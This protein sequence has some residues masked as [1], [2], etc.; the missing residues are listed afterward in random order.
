MAPLEPN[1]GIVDHGRASTRRTGDPP[2]GA[3]RGS[4]AT[5]DPRRARQLTSQAKRA[6]SR[7]V[8]HRPSISPIRVERELGRNLAL[9]MLAAVGVGISLAL[10]TTL[11]PT[12]ARRG[13]LEPLGLAALAAAPFIANLLGV[14]AGRF[15]PRSPRQLALIRVAGSASLS[16]CSSCRRRPIMVVVS[17][18]FWLSLSFGGPFHLRLWGA[19]YPARLRGRVV[20]LLGMGRA[21]AGAL[22]AFGGGLLADHVGGPPAV[23]L[24]GLIG[25][26]VRD[27]LRRPAGPGGRRPAPVLGARLHPR[28]SRASRPRA[29]G[30][31]PGLLRRRPHR[32]GARCT[33]SSM[34]TG[35]TCRSSDV[36]IIG[37]LTAARDDRLVPGLGRR[38]R[39]VRRDGRDADRQRD[40][41]GRLASPTPWHRTSRCC[42]SRPWPP[43]RGVPRSTSASPRSSA[44]TPRMS[45]RAPAMAGWNAITGARGIVAAFLMSALLQAGGRRRDDRT[46]AVCRVVGG[47]GRALHAD[48]RRRAGRDGHDHAGPGRPGGHGPAS[49]CPPL[50]LGLPED[51]GSAGAGRLVITPSARLRW[52]PC[53]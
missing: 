25:M 46:P 22:A 33:R 38:R 2:L 32:R 6:V 36:G 53:A 52:P 49:G 26:V 12:I 11:L 27:R 34:S 30:P 51:G 29:G 50:A 14:F 40:G 48:R 42:G 5:A 35:S 16:R 10:V 28:P 17:V 47:R 43:E 31:R 20:G 9:D 15:G 23:A 21:A 44:S 4:T 45:S 13:G 37:I 41:P 24:A 8:V 1:P 3:N 7:Y 18:V 19:M 39:P